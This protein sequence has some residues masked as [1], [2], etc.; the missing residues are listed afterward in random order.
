MGRHALT[1][2]RV[3]LRYLDTPGTSGIKR[4][5]L[6]LWHALERQGVQ[7]RPNRVLSREFQVGRRRI[8]GHITKGVWE[9]LPVPRGDLVHATTF[10]VNPPRR[11][12]DVVTIHDIIPCV[13]PELYG[14]DAA[15]VQTTEAAVRRAFLNAHV[16]ADSQH[17]KDEL[18]RHFP[19]AQAHRITPVH[20]GIDHDRFYPDVRPPSAWKGT[21]LDALR[22]GMLNVAVVM[23]VE[24]RKRLD[25]LLEAVADLPFVRVVHIGHGT[26]GPRHRAMV[27]RLEQLVP[28]ARARG[29]Y[30]QLGHV[31]DDAIRLVLANADVV[32][33]PSIDEGFSLPPLEALACGARVLASDIPPHAE[34]LG[35]AAVRF[36]L[37]KEG[38]QRALE[39]AWDGGAVRG[40]AFPDQARRLAH[41]RSFT[42]DRTARGTMAAYAL[43]EARA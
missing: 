20:L 15:D 36:P 11:P 26:A 4:Y 30:V 34:I 17:T 9:N 28:A 22:P 37:T 25:L 33:H 31:D 16:V 12:A 3:V 8:G 14:L 10:H 41:A 13:H 1:G 24:M 18:L 7:V 42:W 27:D 32:L 19:D 6:A 40:S 2:M 35:D 5:S 38:I 21:V 39:A 23:N 29:Q 43:A